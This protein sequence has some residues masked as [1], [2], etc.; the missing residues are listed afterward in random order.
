MH[1]LTK[2][3]IEAH[4]FYTDD[5]AREFRFNEFKYISPV[6]KQELFFMKRYC[7]NA[8]DALS[9][10]TIFYDDAYNKLLDKMPIN[11]EVTVEVRFADMLKRINKMTSSIIKDYKTV[12][13]FVLPSKKQYTVKPKEGDGRIVAEINANTFLVTS[14]MNGVAQNPIDMFGLRCASRSLDKWEVEV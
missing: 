1:Y 14:Y 4:V 9:A 5:I 10:P 8:S 7:A 2:C 13:H 3:D 11:T 6:G 12:F